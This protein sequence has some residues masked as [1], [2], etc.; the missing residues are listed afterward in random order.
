MTDLGYGTGPLPFQVP[1]TSSG[2]KL[3]IMVSGSGY[4][5]STNVNPGRIGMFVLFD[6]GVSG[7]VDAFTNELDS[8][9]AFVARSIVLSGV[10]A[11]SHTIRLE[12]KTEG[13]CGTSDTVTDFCTTTDDSDYFDIAVIEMP[14]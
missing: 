1:Y 14:F 13:L 4:R 8:H 9:K 7:E 6:N 11:G 3:L 10:P 2:G 5:S 12:A